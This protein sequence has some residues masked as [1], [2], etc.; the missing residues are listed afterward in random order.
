MNDES[1]LT[2]KTAVDILLLIFIH[3]FKGTNNTFKAFPE[4]LQHVLSETVENVR[5]ES[6]VFPAYEVSC[7][8]LARIRSSVNWPRWPVN[9]RPRET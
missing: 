2:K 3:G 7:T 4:R 9:P 6:I 1:T 8:W 5:A